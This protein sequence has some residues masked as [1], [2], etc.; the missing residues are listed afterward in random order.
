MIPAHV[1]AVSISPNGKD[2]ELK[3]ASALSRLATED[4]MLGVGCDPESGKIVVYGV[5]EIHLQLVRDR[6]KREF[7][8]NAV[9]DPFKIVYRE[10]IRREVREEAKFMRQSGGRRQFAHC[11]LKLEPL[12]HHEG[13]EFACSLEGIPPQ[14]VAHVE[15]GVREGLESS[16][17]IGLYPIVGIKATMVGGSFVEEDSDEMSFKIAGAMALRSGCKKADPA[18]LEP[19]MKCEVVFPGKYAADVIGELKGRRAKISGVS[20]GPIQTAKCTIPLSETFG[21]ANNMRG[22]ASGN[23]SF[24]MEPS[25]FE[26][27]PLEMWKASNDP[28]SPDEP[29]TAGAGRPVKPIKPKPGLSGGQGRAFPPRDE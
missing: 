5:G 23:V 25:H 3:L 1:L 12:P 29:P 18:I 26:E 4:A 19:I 2:E 28:H 14:F 20:E 13:F 17:P 21:F 10:T 7:G 6:L 22:I 16:G 9:F 24:M 15:K 11:I 27:I 8:V